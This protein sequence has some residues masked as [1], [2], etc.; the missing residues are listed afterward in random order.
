MKYL[1]DKCQRCTNSLGLHAA[2][3]KTNTQQRWPLVCEAFEEMK[4]AV[5]GGK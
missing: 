1:N 5:W 2:V 3:A 4:P